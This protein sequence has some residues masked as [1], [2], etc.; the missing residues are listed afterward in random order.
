MRVFVLGFVPILLRLLGVR[1]EFLR[2]EIL[3]ELVGLFAI[4]RRQGGPVVGLDLGTGDFDESLS[5]SNRSIGIFAFHR[6]QQ[7]A[8][9]SRMTVGRIDAESSRA[10]FSRAAD[11]QD[12]LEVRRLS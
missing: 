9:N 10:Q 12:A 7:I 4:L 6:D 8:D 1:Q 3:L 11:D 5:G 2:Q